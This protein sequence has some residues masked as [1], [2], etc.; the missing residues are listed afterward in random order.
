MKN[1]FPYSI[2]LQKENNITVNID[3]TT[4]TYNHTV[5]FVSVPSLANKR[6]YNGLCV[7]VLH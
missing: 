4:H 1:L 2:K 7:T 6:C 3:L 5:S